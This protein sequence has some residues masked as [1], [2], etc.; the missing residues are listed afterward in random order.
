M[1]RFRGG[2]FLMFLA[3]MT[4]LSTLASFS[5]LR[6]GFAMEARGVVVPGTVVDREFVI[7][8]TR[9]GGDT[10]Y[11][12]TVAYSAQGAVIRKRRE[13]SRVFYNRYA[14][15]ARLTVRYLPDQ[16]QTVEFEI[17]EQM[18]SG[19]AFHWL[20]LGLGVVVIGVSYWKAR[21]IVAGIRARRY[22]EVGTGHS[23]GYKKFR[24]GPI[25][26]YVLQWHDAYGAQGQS[27]WT[28]RHRRYDFYPKGTKV[29]F[30]RDLTGNMWWIGDVG[31]REQDAKLARNAKS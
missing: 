19:W 11:R 15:G 20:S 31:P 24:F 3:V 10:I 28:R 17:G 8:H 1:F 2:V 9:R 29:R 14:E 18:R 7:R 22:G 4:V 30:Y 23:L 26:F 6:V 13:V 5:Y 16:P 27:L 25:A 12:V 21:R